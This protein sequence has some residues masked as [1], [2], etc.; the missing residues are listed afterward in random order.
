[1]ENGRWRRILWHKWAKRAV[2]L[3]WWSGRCRC[4]GRE[5]SGLRCKL[6]GFATAMRQRNLGRFR[7]LHIRAC[8]GM[9]WRGGVV[10]WGGGGRGG[11]GASGGGGGRREGG[12]LFV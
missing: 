11:G 5:K 8:L 9:K 3:S 7:S 12:W 1:M 6:A 4:P 2:I 10:G